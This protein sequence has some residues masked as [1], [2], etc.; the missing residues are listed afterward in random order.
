M[1]RRVKIADDGRQYLIDQDG[2]FLLDE[3]GKRIPPLQ[4][5]VVSEP[6]EF[7]VFDDSQGHCAL[8][9]KLT[10]RGGCFK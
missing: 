2:N 3:H 8:C 10:C 5:Q 6:G 9:G 4:S 7:T 1:G